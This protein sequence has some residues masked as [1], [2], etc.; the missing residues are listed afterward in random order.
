MFTVLQSWRALV[1]GIVGGGSGGDFEAYDADVIP[2]CG[3]S[4]DSTG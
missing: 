2:V 4:P 3:E 1:P